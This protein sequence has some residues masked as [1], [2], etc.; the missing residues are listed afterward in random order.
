MAV[1]IS[2]M[3]MPVSCEACEFRLIVNNAEVGCMRLPMERPIAFGSG[4]SKHCP[5]RS[6]DENIRNIRISE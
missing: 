5:L 3:Q 1:I 4:R 2:D 6:V